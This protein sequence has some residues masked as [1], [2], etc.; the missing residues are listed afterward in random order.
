M[1]QHDGNR[2]GFKLDECPI[3]PRP[4]CMVYMD[5]LARL[6]LES[7]ESFRELENLADPSRAQPPFPSGLWRERTSTHSIPPALARLQAQSS[8]LL[9]LGIL[10]AYF[11]R[12]VVAQE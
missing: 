5:Q 7:L 10:G 6:S 3:F 8:S 9:F 12:A 4:T 11:H 2:E 1:I